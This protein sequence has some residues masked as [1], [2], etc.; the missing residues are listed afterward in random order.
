MYIML[1]PSVCT[2]GKPPVMYICAKS[3]HCV[4]L[5]DTPGTVAHQAPLF[6]ESHQARKLEWVATQAPNPRLL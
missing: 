1:G 4:S 6:I 2:E 5:Y 3:L